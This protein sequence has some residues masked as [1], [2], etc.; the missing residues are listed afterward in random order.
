MGQ[1]IV[2]GIEH[3][4]TLPPLKKGL[5]VMLVADSS[6]PFLSIQ[7]RIEESLGEHVKFDAFGSNPLYEDVCN[8]VDIFDKEDCEAIVAV[9][10]GSCID[11]AK[12][13]KLFCHIAPNSNFLDAEWT[14]SQVPLV[15]I[16]TTA[17]TGSESTRYAV[18]Y[19]NGVKQS[20]THSSIIPDFAL[21]EPEALSTLPLYQKKCTLLD[22]LCQG[23][24]SWW[25]INSTEESITHSSFSVKTIIENMD[26]YLTGN[27]PVATRAIM[28]AANHAGQAINITQTTAPHAFSY[29]LT[30]LY[31]LP[32]GHAVAICLPA[33]WKYML[34][35]SDRCTDIRGWGQVQ[36]VFE[37]ISHT[38]QCNT[39]YGTAD[40]FQTMLSRL[41]IKYPHSNN[42][43]KDLMILS[44]SVNPV[45]LKNSP[46][47]IDADAAYKIY[48]TILL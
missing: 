40:W 23:I 18:I 27:N 11:V 3:L 28:N 13:I 30:S 39:P 45:R 24:E 38:M 29:K 20:I 36:K 2:W 33:I 10:G 22:A 46:V 42:R 21:L 8:G 1:Q 14:D 48:N 26:N 35:N 34:D 41:G 6:Y 4:K 44:Q 15:A 17:G 19:H 37:S 31:G 43:E 47:E 5:K 12:C 7:H 32:H 25:S 9:G 16:P